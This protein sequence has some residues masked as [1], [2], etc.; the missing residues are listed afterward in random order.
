MIVCVLVV[1]KYGGIFPATE[2]SVTIA[3]LFALAL[4]ALMLG[5]VV[6]ACKHRSIGSGFR[7]QVSRQRLLHQGQSGDAVR[8]PDLLHLVSSIYS[9]HVPRSQDE[10]DPQ[11]THRK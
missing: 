4:S 7:E 1:L 11:V 5:F 6:L 10:H 2:L 8:H 3:T 9:R